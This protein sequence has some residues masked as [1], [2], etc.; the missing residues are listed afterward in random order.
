MLPTEDQRY[1]L[2]YCDQ[3]RMNLNNKSIKPQIPSISL[4]VT[5]LRYWILLDF[6]SIFG[7]IQ[8]YVAQK[9]KFTFDDILSM[10]IVLWVTIQFY[11]ECLN[12][13]LK[14]NVQT[15]KDNINCL[16]YQLNQFTAIWAFYLMKFDCHLLSY[17]EKKDHWGSYLLNIK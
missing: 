15:L 10:E 3:M 14:Y 13:K 11:G 1:L 8:E 4:A 5:I 7:A 12:S 16:M 6:D 17:L 9:G 2:K